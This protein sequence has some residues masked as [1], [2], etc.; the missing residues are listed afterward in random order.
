MDYELRRDKL[1][2]SMRR[3][4]IE[5]L[6]ITDFVN[7]TYLTGFT[8]DDSYFLVREQGEI[9]L[10]DGRYTTQLEEECPRLELLVRKPGASMIQAVVRALRS[11]GTSRL[12]VEADSMTIG[13]E[14]KIS[15][16]L[17]EMA[18]VP[19]TG[20]VEK[21][22]LIKDKEEIDQL[23]K[24]IRQAEK[25]FAVIRSA[26]LPEMTEKQV[27]N[28]LEHQCRMFGAKAGSFPAI[29]AVGPRAALP[30]AAPGDQRI[31][32][33]SFVLVDWGACEGLYCSDLTR[34]LLIGKILP[35]F[36][37][38]YKVVLEAQTKAI[39][40][41][42]P[43]VL[44]Q[45]VDAVARGV[46]AR[47]GYGRRFTHNLG[48]GVGIQVHEAPRLA[49]KNQ[50]ILKPGMVITV[51]PG[52]Y[53]PGWGGIRIEDDVLVTRS[54]SEVLTHVPKKLEEVIVE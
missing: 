49:A 7:V 54:G 23:R 33:N 31:T 10:T 32:E 53:L 26:L 24:A 2:K 14:D 37:Q 34:V 4:G 39:H 6:L 1:R 47:A 48:H 5:A 25:A 17:P 19:T 46:I 8:G 45:E 35:K 13:L 38:V 36:S 43:G 27:A 22:R 16:K 50:T 9:L 20:L 15:D 12:G 18:I 11:S 3:V 21:L 51:E 52:I 41:I 28:E 30:H 42:R 29:V 44:C 40:A